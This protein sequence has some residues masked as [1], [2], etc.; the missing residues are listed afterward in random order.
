MLLIRSI[1][2]LIVNI[3][4][5]ITC[6]DEQNVVQSS[7]PMTGVH[8]RIVV[9]EARFF[10]DIWIKFLLHFVLFELHKEPPLFFILRDPN[11]SSNVHYAGYTH[12]IFNLLATNLNFTLVSFYFYASFFLLLQKSTLLFTRYSYLEL[13]E[14]MIEAAGSIDGALMHQLLLNV[15]TKSF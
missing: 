6:A 8:L 13:T 15:L 5:K 11:N 2:F 14:R 3:L 9:Y 1:A 7:R 4:A 12:D 10:L